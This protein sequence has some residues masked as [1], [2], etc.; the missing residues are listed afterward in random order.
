MI[1]AVLQLSVAVAI[2]I[3]ATAIDPSHPTVTPAGQVITGGS[4][5]L[6]SITFCTCWIQPGIF[7]F[8]IV[9]LP[10]LVLAAPS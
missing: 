7:G 5:S 2:P 6:T 1:V 8:A 4:V 10:L 9:P 3:S